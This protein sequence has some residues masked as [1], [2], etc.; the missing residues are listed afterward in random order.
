MLTA[1]ILAFLILLAWRS[2]RSVNDVVLQ[3]VDG[4]L[5]AQIEVKSHALLTWLDVQQRHARQSIESDRAAE[6][7][8]ALLKNQPPISSAEF[9]E[10]DSNQELTAI[11]SRTTEL[12]TAAGY[13]VADRTGQFVL[14]SNSLGMGDRLPSEYS[15]Y[16]VR[17]TQ[18]G[19]VVVPPHQ[20]SSVLASSAPDAVTDAKPSTQNSLPAS[21]SQRMILCILVPACRSGQDE[22]GVVG[23]VIE[24]SETFSE[25]LNSGH[26][27]SRIDTYAIDSHARMLSENSSAKLMISQ[28][29]EH[30]GT[31]VSQNILVRDTGIDVMVNGGSRPPPAACPM[32]LAAAGIATAASLS[33]DT[34]HTQLT[35]YRNYRGIPVVGAWRWIPEC[36]FGLIAEIPTRIAFK[37]AHNLAY[38]LWGLVGLLALS[39]G[40]SLFFARM[41]QAVFRR[42]GKA[43]KQLAKMGQYELLDMIGQGGMGE[44]YRARH[45][46]LRRETAVKIC[47]IGSVSGSANQR[48]Q[49]EVQAASQ[50]NNPHTVRIFDYG[51]SEDGT[52][53]YAMELLHGVNL[54]GLIKQFGTL[55]DGRTI[56]ILKQVCESLAEAHG[57]GLVHRDVKPSNVMIGRRGGIADFV[58]VLDFG[59]VRSFG[60]NR[61]VSLTLDGCIAGTPHYMS[62]EASQNPQ[63]IDPRSDLYSLGCLAYHL[64]S[65]QP[66]FTGTNPLEIC[67][68]QVREPAL[69]IDD[70]CQIPICTELS[71]IVMRCIAKSPDDRPQSALELIAALDRATPICPWTREDAE[72]W[73]RNNAEIASTVMVAGPETQASFHTRTPS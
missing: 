59:L 69:R 49:R 50:L 19:S 36:Q 24:A 58:K 35:A 10:L 71:E 70:Q 2:Y 18:S 38:G 27:Y 39:F 26:K 56:Y 23:F 42:L 28:P 33:D 41:A 60:T 64:L 25:L 5:A 6:L 1:L 61:T 63:D 40:G 8:M 34:I 7:L 30:L 32:T 3:T 66:P 72:L 48:F 45:S 44:V 31:G 15:H 62:P 22:L 20:F 37:S 54:T 47:K 51:Q 9:D 73:W 67:L 12:L 53:F 13:F 55:A 4:Q 57:L 43:E 46:L 65:G 68:K 17:L 16:L 14:N 21:H 29:S 52:F 11:L